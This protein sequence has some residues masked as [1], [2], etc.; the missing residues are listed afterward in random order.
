MIGALSVPT[1][2]PGQRSEP[3]RAARGAGAAAREH[4]AWGREE[5]GMTG[6]WSGPASPGA[7]APRRNACRPRAALPE[8]AQ[9]GRSEGGMTPR[10]L[11]SEA[12]LA[13]RRLLRPRV[14]QLAASRLR[15][16]ERPQTGTDDRGSGKGHR[17][18]ALRRPMA[19]QDQS[20]PLHARFRGVPGPPFRKRGAGPLLGFRTQ[21]AGRSSPS[22]EKCR[23][24]PSPG[25]MTSAPTPRI[26]SKRPVPEVSSQ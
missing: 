20:C 16:L 9:E 14:R 1:G 10:R 13:W 7:C 12:A 17:S 5:P 19:G 26:F 22:I 3:T 24:S 6:G 23:A 4:D 25:L 2:A 8:P 11:A 18:T 15:S 21:G